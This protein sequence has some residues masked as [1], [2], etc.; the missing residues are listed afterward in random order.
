MLL[1]PA[2]DL[3]CDFS[4]TNS[5]PHLL[6]ATYG[7]SLT[8]PHPF[9]KGRTK[10]SPPPL[11]G[12][13]KPPQQ[14]LRICIC[15]KQKCD[16][17]WDIQH[18]YNTNQYKNDG[19]KKP[20]QT[21]LGWAVFPSAPLLS[22]PRAMSKTRAAAAP[23]SCTQKPTTSQRAA[24][25]YNTSESQLQKARACPETVKRKGFGF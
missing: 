20:H 23:Q 25:H 2:A 18:Y 12:I 5:L 15:P 7:L 24:L 11:P 10:L 9:W 8:L 13:T 17:G 4:H 6:A 1:S 14:G 21:I 3:L 19:G 22:S 16:F